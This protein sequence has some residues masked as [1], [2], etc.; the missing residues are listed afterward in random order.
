MRKKRQLECVDHI[1]LLVD[2]LFNVILLEKKKKSP[3]LP[4]NKSDLHSKDVMEQKLCCS[5]HSDW[6]QWL[7]WSFL[8]L[9]LRMGGNYCS[10]IICKFVY[11]NLCV[12]EKQSVCLFR[13]ARKTNLR[14]KI[15]DCVHWS[16]SAHTSMTVQTHLKIPVHISFLYLLFNILLWA[17]IFQNTATG[18]HWNYASD[19]ILASNFESLSVC[20]DERV[21]GTLQN[22][23]TWTLLLPSS[24]HWQQL[25][26]STPVYSQ[27]IIC[28]NGLFKE[29]FLKQ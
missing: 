26:L 7:T 8:G 29:S 10:N 15:S 2:L 27:C 6:W 4:E 5:H 20:H 12:H 18:T 11:L 19:F 17:I 14:A 25:Q 23:A 1:E 13:F 16:V 24:P 3:S 28:L 21:E 9:I 22:T